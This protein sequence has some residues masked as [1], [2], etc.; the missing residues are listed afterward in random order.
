MQIPRVD[1]DGWVGMERTGRVAVWV[2]LVASWIAMVAYMWEVS[3]TIPAGERLQESRIAV[4]PT[5][6]TFY[7]AVVFSAMEL[8]LV[9][10]ALWPW[11]PTL[12]ASRLAVSGL[13]L[14]T[15]FVMTTPMSLNR[16][17]GVHRR[18]LAFMILA[19]ALALITLLAYRTG[20]RMTAGRTA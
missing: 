4:V 19:V 5:P 1:P 20:R 17:D 12:Y 7:T 16:M 18:W 10:A 13:A 2:V 9:L 15:W 3:A 11:R 8:G 6:R 14:V